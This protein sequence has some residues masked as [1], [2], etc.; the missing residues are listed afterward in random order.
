MEGRSLV[1]LLIDPKAKWKQRHLFTQIARWKTGSEPDEHMWKK[2]AVR[3]HRY[4]L[5]VD[6]LYDMKKDPNQTVNIADKHLD[7]VQ[8]MR[9]AYQEFWKEARPLMVNETVPMSPT[10]PFQN[11]STSRRPRRVFH[12]EGAFPLGVHPGCYQVKMRQ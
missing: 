10:R 2:Y 7:V 5:V 11:G 1:P 6:Q 9:A 12:V 4:R 8:S 3:N